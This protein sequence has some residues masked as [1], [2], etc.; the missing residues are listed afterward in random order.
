MHCWLR[1]LG[2]ARERLKGFQRPVTTGLGSVLFM[3]FD[4]TFW[5]NSRQL[6]KFGPLFQCVRIRCDW[7]GGLFGSVRARSDAFGSVWR[8]GENFAK[9]FGFFE[10]ALVFAYSFGRLEKTTF[11]EDY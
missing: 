9:I 6:F 11:G 8:S 3:E 1:E 5:C 2:C 4:S 7:F 10:V